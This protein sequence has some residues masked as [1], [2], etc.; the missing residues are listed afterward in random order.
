MLL[1]QPAT[2]LGWHRALV[3]HRWAAFGRRRGPG[4]PK[5]PTECRE[6]VLRLASE[7][8]LWGYERIRGE[9]LKLGLR[10]SSTSIRNL[11]RRHRVLPAPR[12]AGLTWRRFLQAHGRAILACDY[13][14]VDTVFLKRLYVLF[15]LELASRRILFTA[16]SDHVRGAWAAQ[17]ARNL[18]WQLQEAEV[19]PR[20][21]IHDRDANFPAGFDA[22]FLAEGLEVIRTPVRAPNANARC[23][24]WISSVR[25]ECLDWLLIL[26]RQHLEAVLADYVE[27]YNGHRPHRSLGLRPPRGPTAIPAVIGGEVVRRTRL[28][29]LINEY[30]RQAA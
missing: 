26:N 11:L 27:H 10:I 23:K 1:V 4:R 9:L 28:H 15:F 8:P 13:C 22:V 16:C 14:T 24:R 2:I 18:A 5:L 12:R 25:G 30:S 7:N 19:K 17:Q 21:L 3:H 29:G 6:L 20:F